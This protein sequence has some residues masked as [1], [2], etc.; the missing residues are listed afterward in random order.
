MQPHP[1]NP[2]IYK[3]FGEI[4]RAEELGSGFRTI[5]KYCKEYAG[6]DPIIKDEDLF[7]FELPIPKHFFPFSHANDP[8]S[9]LV[10]DPVIKILNFCRV[11]RAFSEIIKHCGF[12]NRT[13]FR[14]KFLNPLVQNGKLAITIP[15]KP[16]SS[17]QRYISA[18]EQR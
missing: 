7:I 16:N 5:Y 8:V 1:K 3:F 15:E 12:K 11:P 17:K 13:Y 6:A 4:G 18:Q 9:D 10:I 2:N 14:N